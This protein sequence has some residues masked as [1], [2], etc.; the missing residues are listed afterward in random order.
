MVV[1]ELSGT[2]AVSLITPNEIVICDKRED[3]NR[4]TLPS[5]RVFCNP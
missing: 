1:K 2:I 5:N 4:I 3:R